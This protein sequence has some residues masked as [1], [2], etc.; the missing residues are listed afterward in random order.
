[1]KLR[2]LKYDAATSEGKIISSWKK[3]MSYYNTAGQQIKTWA[4]NYAKNKTFCE[5]PVI[6]L[7]LDVT[8]PNSKA[9]NANMNKDTE[10]C[11]WT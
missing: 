10:G 9:I 5:E 2:S 3:E 11:H 8:V 6:S 7:L 4:R 1:L